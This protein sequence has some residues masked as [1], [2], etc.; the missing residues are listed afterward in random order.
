MD[1]VECAC[2][3]NQPQSLVHGI[4]VNRFG[5]RFIN[6]DTYQGRV[7]QA[8]LIHQGG[9][10]YLI[11]DEA[12]YAPNWLSIQASWVCETVTELETEIGLPAGSLAATLDYFNEHAEQGEDPLF[13]KRAPLLTPLRPPL[14]AFDLRA[15]KF[16]YA[17]FTLGGLH[18]RPDGAVLDRDGEPIAGLYAA[19]RTTSGVAAQ[20]YASG[21]SLG[22]STFFGR[23]AGLSAVGAKT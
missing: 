13:H 17:P 20:G 14:A 2:P 7:G 21:L 6:E 19:G 10:A 23:L 15:S 4:I 9:E 11:V 8:S 18:T 3:F 1:A 12:H 16:I 5:Q 22:D